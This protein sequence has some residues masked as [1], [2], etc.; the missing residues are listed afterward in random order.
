MKMPNAAHRPAG[1]GERGDARP[2]GNKLLHTRDDL[3]KAV[4]FSR[5]LE[6]AGQDLVA[7]EDQY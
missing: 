7:G 5:L 3:I 2:G 1:S 6:L 4:N